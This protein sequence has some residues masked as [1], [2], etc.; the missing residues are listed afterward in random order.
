MIIALSQRQVLNMF[1]F[2]VESILRKEL[3][4]DNLHTGK[5]MVV[6]MITILPWYKDLTKTGPLLF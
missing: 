3:F 4:G 2:L 5:Y 1:L 6:M